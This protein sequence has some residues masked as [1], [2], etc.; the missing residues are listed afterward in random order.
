[1][2]IRESRL[3][4]EGFVKHGHESNGSFSNDVTDFHFSDVCHAAAILWQ[5]NIA[6]HVAVVP[7]DS[8]RIHASAASSNI[9]K[10]SLF[11]VYMPYGHDNTHT[12]LFV[13]KLCLIEMLQ[14]NNLDYHV[15]I[16]GDL[17]AD[18]SREQLRTALLKRFCE[19]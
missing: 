13:G 10:F 1:M 17:N 19:N 11:N 4:E 6:A 3:T 7:T 14:V 16:T 2:C 15:I 9:Y 8:P 5:S 18:P 12:D